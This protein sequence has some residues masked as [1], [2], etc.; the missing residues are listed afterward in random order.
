[1]DQIKKSQQVQ[2]QLSLKQQLLKQ[3]ESLKAQLDL[4][5]LE[6]FEFLIDITIIQLEVYTKTKKTVSVTAQIVN[7]G[8]SHYK[9]NEQQKIKNL[10]SHQ[11]LGTTL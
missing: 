11:N 5:V 8:F 3:F 7:H 2:Q 9:V 1:M 4:Y 6:M 10:V